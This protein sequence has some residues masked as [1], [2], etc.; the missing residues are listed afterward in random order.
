[1]QILATHLYVSQ[2]AFLG[3]AE[4]AA[5]SLWV[6]DHCRAIGTGRQVYVLRRNMLHSASCGRSGLFVTAF[7]FS[8][9]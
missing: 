7:F 5:E 1:M 9:C 2:V 4:T 8:S 3:P 6:L